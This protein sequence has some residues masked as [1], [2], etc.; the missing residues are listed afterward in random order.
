M[1]KPLAQITH[2]LKLAIKDFFTPFILKLAIFPFIVSLVFWV[3]VFSFFSDEVVAS[4]FAFLQPYLVIETSWLSWIQSPLEFLVRA[5][6]FAS[7]AGSFWLLRFLTLML[8]NALLTPFVVKFIYKRHYASILIAPDTSLFLS[9]LY[10]V[11]PYILYG[12]FFLFLLPLYFIP[13]L[14]IVGIT[15]LNYWL[16]SKR[17]IQDVGENIFSKAELIHIKQTHKKPIRNLV[18]TLF[19][20]SLIP[21]VGFFVPLFASVALSHLFFHIKGGLDYGNPN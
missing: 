5:F 14:W 9:L 13:I 17:L 19:L 4:L 7:L 21:F 8:I 10:L 11:T 16:F 18:I 20:L 15:L 6:L 3:L 12:I 1:G 2:Y